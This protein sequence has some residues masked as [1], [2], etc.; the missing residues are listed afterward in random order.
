V[1]MTDKID[2]RNIPEA[3]EWF[4]RMRR[5]RELDKTMT[6]SLALVPFALG[7]FCQG[8]GHIIGG[9]GSWWALLPAIGFGL[10]AFGLRQWVIRE[11]RK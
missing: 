11:R 9:A 2:A 3:D 8:L 4:I 10:A 5:Q 6:L 7:M 1:G